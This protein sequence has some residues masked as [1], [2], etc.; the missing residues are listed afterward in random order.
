[1]CPALNAD[2]QAVGVTWWLKLLCLRQGVPGG[3][4]PPAGEHCSPSFVRDNEVLGHAPSGQHHVGEPLAGLQLSGVVR[5]AWVIPL[6]LAFLDIFC[7]TSTC[8]RYCRQRP[9][10]EVFGFPVLSGGLEALLIALLWETGACHTF[11]ALP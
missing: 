11:T 8:F 4:C 7:Q 10:Y 6:C 2:F 9:S 5:S 1:M 3:C